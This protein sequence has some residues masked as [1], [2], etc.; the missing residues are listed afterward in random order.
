[1]L[2][3][4]MRVY[5]CARVRVCVCGGVMDC[6]WTNINV[7]VASSKN[8]T[9]SHNASVAMKFAYGSPEAAAAATNEGNQTV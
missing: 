3:A 2:C 8:Q 5:L 9:T 7:A 1:M 6:A 4:H